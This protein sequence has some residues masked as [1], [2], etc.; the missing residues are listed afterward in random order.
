VVPRSDQLIE[1][2]KPCFCLLKARLTTGNFLGRPGSAFML[3]R[4]Q[5]P[6]VNALPSLDKL[7]PALD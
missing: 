1:E 7:P 3:P 6:L 4:L 5:R 2:G